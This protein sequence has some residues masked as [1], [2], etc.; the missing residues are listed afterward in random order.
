V[1]LRCLDNR[2]GLAKRSPEHGTRLHHGPWR[3]STRVRVVEHHLHV[4]GADLG[5]LEVADQ[6]QHV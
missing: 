1:S 6:R 4:R 3:E 5:E 2:G